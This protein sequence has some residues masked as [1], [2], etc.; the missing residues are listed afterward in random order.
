MLIINADDFGQSCLA[1]DRIIS[2]YGRGSVTSTSA[3]V[4]MEDSQ[5]AAALAKDCDINVGL[6]LNLTQECTQP[7]LS[8]L[9]SDYHARIAKYLNRSNYDCIIY[10]PALGKQFEYIYR[11]QLDEFER[12]YG[13]SPS[14][15]NG[16]HH[17]HL[18]TNILVGGFI[19][20]GQRVRRSF[21]FARGE[22]SALNRL[23]RAA[24]DAWLARRYIITDYFY[25][26]PERIRT[27]RLAGALKLAETSSVELETHPE[28]PEEFSW[29]TGDAC[30]QAFSG[31]QKGTYAQLPSSFN[32]VNIE[33][34]EQEY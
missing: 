18:C 34:H 26:L 5:R 24:V 20:K 19:A 6:H 23:Y 11:A 17:M 33:Q 1:T 15:I 31:I 22:K 8:S 9:Y 29:L 21:T 2:C 10:N 28:R 14:H 3:M 7:P 25:S 30:V 4:F 32:S 12:L 16:H 13:M 27:G